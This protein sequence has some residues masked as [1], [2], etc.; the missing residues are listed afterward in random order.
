MGR[1]FSLLLVLCCGVAVLAGVGYR[2]YES[3]GVAAPAQSDDDHK[4]VNTGRVV[5]LGTLEPRGGVRDVGATAGD[6]VKQ[7]LVVAGQQVK[8]GATLAYL[9]S[10]DLRMAEKR[11]AELAL[12]EA[13]ER[14]KIEEAYGDNL[15]AEAQLGIEQL[16]LVQY[17]LEAQQA[18]L[19][20]SKKNLAVASGD[21]ERMQNLADKDSTIV[22][23]QELNH[24]KLLVDQAHAK[25]TSDQAML[26][27]S[28]AAQSFSVKEAQEKLAA[29]KVNRQRLLSAIDLDSLAGQVDM[30]GDRVQM[31]IVTA[32]MAGEVLE[33]VTHPGETITQQPIVRMGD[34]VHM[35][36]VAEVYETQVF[37]VAIGQRA[38]V[39]SD[40]LQSPLAGAVDFIGNTVARNQVTSLI[41]TDNTDLR[42]VKVHVRLDDS[43]AAAKLVNLQVRV[44]IETKGK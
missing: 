39:T 38:T 11:S 6:Q 26:A 14:R 23:P 30:A 13:T 1:L 44:Q 28:Q 2:F 8:Q 35:Y 16:K 33:I 9:E 3:A 27:K 43:V 41:P 29:A 42:V 22:S 21:L 5:S 15:V 36:A 31:S 19:A 10:Y 18:A 20:L 40:A 37:A 34:T 12:K 17:D 7:I 4:P 32:P 24:Q 25:L